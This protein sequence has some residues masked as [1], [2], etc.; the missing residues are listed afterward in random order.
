MPEGF[1]VS[2]PELIL[3]VEQNPAESDED[4][5]TTQLVRYNTAQAGPSEWR[6]LAV[7]VRDQKGMLQGGLTGFTHWNWPAPARNE[8]LPDRT[9]RERRA[10]ARPYRSARTASRSAKNLR[11]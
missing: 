5:L 7:F 2:K 3:E 1:W 8:P 10:E 4:Y 9:Q 6:P 11:F